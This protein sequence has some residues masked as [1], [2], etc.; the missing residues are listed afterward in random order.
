[1]ALLIAW[2]VFVGVGGIL[3]WFGEPAPNFACVEPGILYRSGQPGKDALRVL[4]RRYGIRT[5]VNLRSPTKVERDPLARQEVA[6]ALKNGIKFVNLPYGTPSPEAQVEK[7]LEIMEDSSNQP[8][9]VHCAAG[10]ERSGVMVA[11]YR[12]RKNG[13]SLTEA[14]QEMETFGF[15]PRKKPDMCRLVESI[16]RSART[17]PNDIGKS[18]ACLY[19]R[20]QTGG[21]CR[22]DFGIRVRVFR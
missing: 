15:E 11:A 20:W 2:T 14:L 16:A 22:T 19:T 4:Q 21:R 5:L 18:K 10:K 3:A 9:L 17:T 1:M 8:V 12:I 6:F 13:W 7:F